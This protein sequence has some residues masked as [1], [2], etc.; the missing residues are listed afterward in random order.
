MELLDFPEEILVLILKSAIPPPDPRISLPRPEF[1]LTCRT[2]HRIGLP[3]L[4]HTLLIKSPTKAALVHRT[5]LEQPTLVRHVRHLY[6]RVTTLSLLLV[7]RAIGHGKGSLQTLDFSI[8]APWMS[9]RPDGSDEDEPLTAVP[10]RN[11]AVRHGN[12]MFLRHSVFE[13]TGALAEAIQRWPNLEVVEIE[14]RILLTSLPLGRP[15][16]VALALSRA[17]ALRLIRTALPPVWDPS[18]LVASENP[19]L[20]RI[21]LT[22]SELSPGLGRISSRYVDMS[23]ASLVAHKDRAPWLVEAQKHPRLMKLIFAT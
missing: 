3:F 16:P 8:N 5:L 17:P 4:Y 20:Q 22:A 1:L 11:L 6:S 23:A 10:V 21:V 19:S 15:H 12:V 18:L 14:P 9:G 13:V 2:L 7:L